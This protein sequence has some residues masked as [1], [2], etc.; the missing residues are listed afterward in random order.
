M[1]LSKVLETVLQKS[2]ERNS[3]TISFTPDAV[4]NLI[5][6]FTYIPEESITFTTYFRRYIFGSERK[7][8]EKKVR[9]LI[10][11]L[12]PV[13]QE[14]YCDYI[15]PKTWEYNVSRNSF[16]FLKNFFVKKTLYSI[17]DTSV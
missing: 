8:D 15:L 10:Q 13:E 4:T 16:D 5:S 14:K 9:L 12:S 11:K 6:E 1:R 3:S 7:T 2:A 17:R